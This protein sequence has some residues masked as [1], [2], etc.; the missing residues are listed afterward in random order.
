MNRL[1]KWTWMMA[2]LG[3]CGVSVDPTVTPA[4]EADKDDVSVAQSALVSVDASGRV[5]ISGTAAADTATVNYYPNDPTTIIVALNG[6]TNVYMLNPLFQP[7][8]TGVVFYGGDGNDTFTNNT[9][10]PSTAYGNNGDDVLTGG[11]GADFLEGDLGQDTLRGNGG[12]DTLWGSGGSDTLWGGPGDDQLYGHGGNDV[13]HGE[14]GNDLLNG[15]SGND[16]LFGEY[17]QDTIMAVGLGVDTI[18]GG[19]QWDYLWVDSSD[20]ITDASPNEQSLGYVHIIS[21]FHHVSYDGGKTSTAIGLDPLGENLPDPIAQSADNVTA[22]VN[23]SNSPLFR[24]SGP[25][26]NDVFQNLAGDCYFMSAMAAIAGSNPEFIRNMV[27]A[28]G[29]GTY[30]VRFYTAGIPDYVRVDGDLY[31]KNGSLAYARLNGSAINGAGAIW[32]PI[33]EKAFA[34]FRNDDSNYTT[35][36]GGNVVPLTPQLNAS[37]TSFSWNDGHVSGCDGPCMAMLTWIAIGSPAGA[38]KTSVETSVANYLAW[39][40]QQLNQKMPLVAGTMPDST[41]T[42]VLDATYFRRGKHIYT[43]DHLTVDAFGLPN[44]IVLRNPY[45]SYVTFK[46]PAHIF[47]MLSAS[48]YVL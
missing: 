7:A 35:I 46:D 3:A 10:L 48:A 4:L 5:I 22:K 17:G 18:T 47:F 41:D 23:Y 45:G 16:Q 21:A 34:I 19:P 20:S 6:T 13:L 31:E 40:Q 2:L 11:S 30:A 12:D 15:G 14:D 24:P 26:R 28:L 36:D 9:S 44:G 33:V 29:D 1:L 25:N 43:I 38:Y 37:A 8:L 27:I 39:V 32:T 42:T